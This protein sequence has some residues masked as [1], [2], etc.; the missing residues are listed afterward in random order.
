[1]KE[2]KEKIPVAI[3]IR[4]KVRNQEDENVFNEEEIIKR[5]LLE[6]EEEIRDYC[7]ERN[8]RIIGVYKDNPHEHWRKEDVKSGLKKLLIDSFDGNFKKVI[9]IDLYNID[10]DK[11]N[12]AYYIGVISNNDIDIEIM[13]SGTY[14]EDFDFDIKVNRNDLEII[15][16]KKAKK[17]LKKLTKEKSK[18]RG[19]LGYYKLL[20]ECIAKSLGDILD[21]YDNFYDYLMKVPED[22]DYFKE[23]MESSNP[24]FMYIFQMFINLYAEIS[25][26]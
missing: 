2:L 24:L 7:R 14:L 16:M 23:G 18:L 19:E 13:H 3:Y 21:E 22:F 20:V 6:Q 12:S 1:M 15:E 5:S 9:M 26:R 25:E 10:I 8:Y 4:G 17:F 11:N